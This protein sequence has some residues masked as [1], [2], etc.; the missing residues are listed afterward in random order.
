MSIGEEL[1]VCAGVARTWGTGHRAVVA[2]HGTDAV[3]RRG[4]RTALIGRSGSGKSTL[5][6]LMAGLDT[7]TRGRVAWPAWDGPPSGRPDRVGVVF[8]APSLIP[9]LDALEN[10]ALPLILHGV[11]D[12]DA[13]ARAAATMARLGVGDLVGALPEELSGGQ[14]QRVVCARVLA[15]GPAL[16]LADEPTGR[17][18]RAAADR[19]IDVLLAVADEVD[20][21]LVVATHD[22]AV[23]A[24]LTT[25]WEMAD[26]RLLPPSCP[27]GRVATGAGASR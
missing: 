19:V 1:V 23:A 18:D 5:L 21:A 26:G 2:V 16:I 3:V 12:T 13:R 9:S 15:A 22:P 20:A 8:Q 10:V 24:R 17:L 6:H 27:P 4:A 14:A 7:P 25:R 11:L